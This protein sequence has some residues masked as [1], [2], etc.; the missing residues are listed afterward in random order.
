V[1]KLNLTHGL[2]GI[3][4]Y[5][6]WAGMWQR[7]TNPKSIAYENYGGRG[8]KVCSR[9]ESFE[10]FFEDMGTRPQGKYSIERVD[11]DGNYEPTNCKWADYFEQARNKR[12]RK[13]SK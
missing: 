2:R 13:D 3:P 7:T 12:K 5:G 4:E 9:W 11:N 10:N 6:V 8:I 1:S